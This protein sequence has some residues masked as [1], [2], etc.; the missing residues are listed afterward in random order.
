MIGNTN[1]SQSDYIQKWVHEIAQRFIL[2]LD[3][4]NFILLSVGPFK[5]AIYL[6]WI[7]NTTTTTSQTVYFWFL[8]KYCRYT[9][10][11]SPVE[12]IDKEE[13]KSE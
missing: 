1:P 12:T 7:S 3:Y 10:L 8:I 13:K 11:Y 9:V 2:G 4:Y 6:L 5:K